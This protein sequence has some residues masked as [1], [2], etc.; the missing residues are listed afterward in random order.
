MI[1]E[2]ICR[3]ELREHFDHDGAE[4]IDFRT[5]ATA[6]LGSATAKPTVLNVRPP[7]IYRLTRA[8]ELR[9]AS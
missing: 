5:P 6:R 4:W 7:S 8:S 2:H 1:G 3:M 9:E